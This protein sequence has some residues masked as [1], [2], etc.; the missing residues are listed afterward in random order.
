MI[1]QSGIDCFKRWRNVDN[2]PAWA[3][4]HR[5]NS[6]EEKTKKSEVDP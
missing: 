5:Q 2:K 6:S 1:S 4:V 3:G